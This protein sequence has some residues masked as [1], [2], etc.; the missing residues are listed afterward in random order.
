MNEMP[1]PTFRKT[2]RS[3]ASG[4]D[5]G[6]ETLY[7]PKKVSCGT[8]TL[9]DMM[10]AFVQYEQKNEPKNQL[11]LFNDAEE[12]NDV[13]EKQLS[14]I[15]T[16]KTISNKINNS[17]GDS[18]DSSFSMEFDELV[19][20]APKFDST[21]EINDIGSV[22][23]PKSIS[24]PAS[25]YQPN[26]VTFNENHSASDINTQNLNIFFSKQKNI[27]F[28]VTDE[29]QPFQSSN[30]L[31]V[32]SLNKRRLSRT[33]VDTFFKST[34]VIDPIQVSL[35]IKVNQVPT[36]KYINQ[37]KSMTAELKSITKDLRKA[38]SVKLNEI[39]DEPP[40]IMLKYPNLTSDQTAGIIQSISTMKEFYSNVST[41]HCL[42]RLLEVDKT[43]Q[44]EVLKLSNVVNPLKATIGKAQNQ[45]GTKRFTRDDVLKIC[46]DIENQKNQKSDEE[47][48]ILYNLLV[49]SIPFKVNSILTKRDTPSVTITN[50]SKVE[51][52]NS[53]S[54][55]DFY[56]DISIANRNMKLITEIREI[57][58]MVPHVIFD[59]RSLTFLISSDRKKLRF[60]VNLRI[61]DQYPWMKLILVAVRADFGVTE[62]DG[63]NYIANVLGQIQLG[64]KQI[65]RFVDTLINKYC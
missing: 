47:Y 39:A 31:S 64:P 6:E 61:P 4:L 37:L 45:L 24:K 60:A 56:T 62:N 46:N 65:K 13:T 17:K 26:R 49:S 1:R 43:A 2:F 15:F 42:E 8:P 27:E 28:D 50:G 21:T 32:S 53:T 48:K 9:Q 35:P 57:T 19:K 40:E 30:L 54:A 11:N 20:K 29:Q 23:Q 33:N 16:K 5:F 36:S 51:R 59:G 52:T 38:I 14:P 10:K 22:Y 34:H 55:N 25:R 12:A 41:A 18:D 63:R 7:L 44:S 3:E 58:K